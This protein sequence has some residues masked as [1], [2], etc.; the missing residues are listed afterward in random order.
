MT[1]E[2]YIKE[3]GEPLRLWCLHKWGDLKT[4]AEALKLSPSL[5]SRYINYTTGKKPGRAFCSKIIKYGFDEAIVHRLDNITD[6]DLDILDKSEIKWLY[7][8]QKEL[9]RELRKLIKFYEDRV[10]DM[11]RKGY[12]QF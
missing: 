6:I 5:L 7:L 12:G 11:Q 8:E 4:A 10:L 1:K 2:D 9:V 3:F